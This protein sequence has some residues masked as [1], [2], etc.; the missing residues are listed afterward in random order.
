MY[1]SKYKNLNISMND[2]QICVFINKQLF[3]RQ[4]ILKNPSNSA[5]NMT[6]KQYTLCYVL[7]VL[8]HFGFVPPLKKI[9]N[10]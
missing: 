7:F 4:F 10:I 8:S 1:I 6:N 5:N 2:K 9:N 3:M